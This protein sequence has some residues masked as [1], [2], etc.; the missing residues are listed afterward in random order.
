MFI[1]QSLLI[2]N[3]IKIGITL[4]LVLPTIF[5]YS[6]IPTDQ[7]CLGAIPVCQPVYYQENS[8][9]GTGNYPNEINPGPSCMDW[10]ELN[11]V[12]Y[13][14]TV[15]TGGDLG[16]LITPN[17][18]DNDYDWAVYN[19]TDAECSDIYYDPSL[20]VSCNW[21][22][23]PGPTG[24]N[25][26]SNLNHQNAYG[27]PFNALIPV[28]VGETYV[29]NVSNFSSNQYGYTLDFSLSTASIYDNVPPYISDVQ[30]TIGCAGETQL[31]FEF[32]ENV[33][34][35]TVEASD[36]SLTGPSGETYTITSVFGEACSVGGDQENAFDLHFNPP[37]Y[38]GGQ[39][40][41]KVVGVIT[42]LCGNN[43]L[44]SPVEFELQEGLPVVEIT[45]L[46]P[47]WCENDQPD[48]IYGNHYPETGN[49][50]FTGPG[51]TDLG[52]NSALF[53]PGA[54]G[55]GGPYTVTYE[56]TDAGGCSNSISR[57]VTVQALP[58]QYTVAGGGSFC[59]GTP[60]PHVFLAENESE[61][62][63]NYELYRNGNSTG[64]I[65][66]GTGLGGID[67]GPQNVTGT[68]TVKASGN[69]GESDMLG[70]V[71]I[72]QAA[73]PAVYA[74]GG[75]GYY[76][77]N[78]DGT[79]ITLSNSEQETE[80]ELLLDSMPTGIILQGTGQPLN[81][82]NITMPGWY[83]VYASN[84]ICSDT[85]AGTVE[86]G[87]NPVPVADAG[88]DQSIPY[89]TWTTLTG[90]ASGG[91]GGYSWHWEP[92][93]QLLDPDVQ[94]PITVNLN[95]TTVFTLTVDDSNGCEDQDDVTVTV[96]G[97]PLG[98]V[99]T[100]D[101]G[102]IC[103]GESTQ[104]HALA[105]GG[106]GVY[107]YSWTSTP[108][109]FTSVDPDP[110]VSPTVTTQYTATVSDGY[111]SVQGDVSVTVNPLPGAQ[112]SAD[113]TSIPYGSWTTVRSEATVGTG[114][115]TYSWSPAGMVLNPSLQNT[116]TVHLEYS[117]TFTV[118]IINVTTGC[119]DE[120]SV[121]VNVYGG[122]LQI[123]SVSADPDE[124]CNTGAVVQ[125]NSNVAGGTE[126]YSY[127]WTSSPPGFTATIP[128]PV[129]YPTQ[130]TTYTLSV[131]DGNAV[132]NKS[133]EVVVHDLPV[134]DA[135][136]D[137]SIPYGTWTL[138][139][140]SASGGSGSYLWHWE[141][142]N[143]LVNPNIHNPQT[144]NMTLSSIF[145]LRATDLYGCWDED[146]TVV[147]VY[148]GPLGVNAYANPNVICFGEETEL[149]SLASGGSG[150]Y[151][152]TWLDGEGTV[153]SH[154][155]SLT[156]SPA[157]TTDYIIEVWDG[158]NP[159]SDT[160]IV[161]VNPLPVVNLIPPGSNVIGHDTIAACVYDTL[162]LDAGNPGCHYVWSNQSWEQ[163]LHAATTGIGFDIS[164]YWV[165]VTNPQTGC[166]FTDTLTI[167]FS[168]AECTGI[169]EQSGDVSV[170][171]YPNPSTGELNVSIDGLGSPAE[172][173]LWNMTGQILSKK[174]LGSS[175][176]NRYAE[177]IDLSGYHNGVYLLK[178]FNPHFV[179]LNK[180]ILER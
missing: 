89:G 106:S 172:M 98:V 49:S 46:H 33:L 134:A 3:F 47:F 138:L 55:P 175:G 70:S 48:T 1:K 126:T 119:M 109:G 41:L 60:G 71:Q 37:I 168:F 57:L 36:F 105:S 62:Y 137:N 24:A 100:A 50:T 107:T 15:K 32:S 77:E 99:V 13:I 171:I 43:A 125:L 18:P 124:M 83:G 151:E 26:G 150:N 29:L 20:E 144:V 40:V 12:W 92:A 103:I 69:C 30:Q 79:T 143:L 121:E 31:S 136:E 128:N 165:I 156:V 66:V 114:P 5:A 159:S 8:Y 78:I 93:D 139:Q 85:M 177:Q 142:A 42:D 90:S 176:M 56:Y 169:N 141:P 82:T 72:V 25:G 19:L 76:C 11:D 75:G 9:S 120:A 97:G 178:I 170:R 153:L 44:T 68:Y 158:F 2:F 101:D 86:V 91:A 147:N 163:T 110:V 54:A 96:V 59:E 152:Y 73:L 28:N 166:A 6:Q 27:T 122:P 22:G 53:D 123:V 127:A 51:I 84:A 155:A 95:T 162:L 131:D 38:N 14:I 115:F 116:E 161:T 180:I 10:G 145:T 81:F 63:V 4:S 133:V 179:H 146:Q 104:L 112:A 34:C 64:Q 58:I 132:V 117:V 111:N 148:G 7:D 80:Y 65:V 74:V 174:T 160:I 23:T 87:I 94:N 140:G 129:A 102:S 21:S 61:P 17:N 39:Y 154:D 149:S 164:T 173:E 35:S 45:G 135:G 52:N 167:F 157:V 16:F 130:T 108:P 113:L 88:T 67:F 118:T